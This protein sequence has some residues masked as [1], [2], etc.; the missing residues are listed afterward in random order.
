MD[1]TQPSTRVCSNVTVNE[2]H[3]DLS[4][5]QPN[6]RTATANS[7]GSDRNFEKQIAICGM[8]MRLPGGIRTD[9]D[10]YRF[11]LGKRDARTI[12]PRDR[13]DIDKYYNEHNKPGTINTKHGYFL[14]DVDLKK[15]DLSMFNMTPEEAS[16]LDP[17]QRLLLE[18]VREAFESA[19][20]AEFRGK[21]IGTYASNYADDWKEL[22]STDMMDHSPYKLGGA[23]DFMLANRIAHQY[24]LRG[25]R[26]VCRK[27][28]IMK[29]APQHAPLTNTYAA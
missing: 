25:P 29:R 12:F 26:Y 5:G 9:L 6:G 27:V 17:S 22:Q 2:Q 20:E 24:D 8:G 15:M 18:V 3:T 14:Q 1:S 11:L 10:L 21:N 13:F 16:R 19:G 7:A 23:S 28:F 4:D